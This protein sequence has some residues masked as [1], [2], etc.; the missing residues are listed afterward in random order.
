MKPSERCGTWM[1]V[2]MFNCGGS[3]PARLLAARVSSSAFVSSIGR[4]SSNDPEAGGNTRPSAPDE[5]RRWGIDRT[6]GPRPDSPPAGRG[7]APAVRRGALP[8]SASESSGQRRGLRAGC[9]MDHRRRHLRDGC[10]DDLATARAG[11][12]HAGRTR[13]HTQPRPARGAPEDQRNF[14]HGRD[15][16]DP[17]GS[18]PVRQSTAIRPWPDGSRR[19]SYS[20]RLPQQGNHDTLN[21]QLVRGNQIGKPRVLRA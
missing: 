4:R 20:T 14:V 1:S 2:S 17:A 12:H 11:S 18:N 6:T 8:G 15:L 13:R 10:A 21:D 5:I 3:F 9:W 16:Q 19:E 7:R